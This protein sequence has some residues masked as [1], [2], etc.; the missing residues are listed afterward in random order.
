MTR[1]YFLFFFLFVCLFFG[2]TVD[3][4]LKVLSSKCVIKRANPILTASKE[5]VIFL[6]FKEELDNLFFFVLPLLP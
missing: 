4:V 5:F 2:L 1:L 3:S 6:L